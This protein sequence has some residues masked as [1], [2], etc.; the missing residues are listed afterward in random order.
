MKILAI[1]NKQ[2]EIIP[3]WSVLQN[4]NIERDIVY[5]HLQSK[6][7]IGDYIEKSLVTFKPNYIFTHHPRDNNSDHSSLFNILYES[8]K[9]ANILIVGSCQENV[10][11]EVRTPKENNCRLS[12]VKSN[13]DNR[14]HF[15][16]LISNILC[17]PNCVV[18]EIGVFKGA[19]TEYLSLCPNIS[20]IYAIDP[21]ED[22]PQ[23]LDDKILL[24]QIGENN[25][26]GKR[27]NVNSW[28]QLYTYI[29]NKF[30]SNKKVQIIRS[31]SEQAAFIVNEPLDLVFID[32]D[33]SYEAVLNDLTLW[34]P[35]IKSGGILA[36]HD[37]TWNRDKKTKRGVV[38]AVM[39]FFEI[40][41]LECYEPLEPNRNHLI[42]RQIDRVWW[43]QKR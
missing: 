32:G 23:Y 31:T 18:A 26:L 20:K 43:Q 17:P 42:N 2:E 39:E 7:Q 4:I 27:I 30:H 16:E 19:T 29:R 22:N 13:L 9:T 35:K 40:H 14:K 36:G 33:H 15:L 28:D 24:K 10:I 34:F 3:G 21:W 1:L 25:I 8:K 38:R 11:C 37:F 5:T 6:E 41:K 12:I